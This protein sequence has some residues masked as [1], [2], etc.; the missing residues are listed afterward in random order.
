M[1]GISLLTL[2][3]GEL[4]GSES[5]TSGLLHALARTGTLEYRVY[6]PPVAPTA[7][8]GLPHELVPEYHAARTIPERLLA[9]GLAATRPG[10]L[11]RRL[12]AADVVHYPLTIRL[13][14]VEAPSVVTMHDLQHLDLPALFSRGERAF[15]VLAWHRSIRGAASVV[16]PSMFVRDRAESLLGVEPSRLRVIPH[17]IDHTRFSPGASEHEPFLLYPARRWPHKNH[18]RL[19]EAFAL[20]RRE[21]PELRL[22]LTGGGHSHAVLDGVEVRGHV[23]P[24]ELV[25]LYR[26]AAA[27][28]F[29]S[30]YEGFGQPVLEAMAC[31]C[32]VACS[33]IPALTEVAGGAA[34]TF[35]P[36]DA[37]SIAAGVRELL[38]DR[39]LHRERGLARAA[40]FTWERAAAE[41]EAVYRELL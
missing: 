13:P 31:G 38:A 41:Y 18:A 28:V 23:E 26:S 32:P 3:P 19:L 36:D 4:G 10:P 29:P 7:H 40:Q 15:R 14:A 1:I 8:E 30:L 12:A 34:V 25:A 11:R 16:C 2:V 17:G 22:V 39:P 20:L 5:A 33:A 35:D 6:L 37:E 24:D 21:Q 9:M 27:V